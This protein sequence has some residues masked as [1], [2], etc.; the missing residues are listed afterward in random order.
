[1]LPFACVPKNT[2]LKSRV[3]ITRFVLDKLNIV[4]RDSR[5]EKRN[6][7]DVVCNQEIEFKTVHK[8]I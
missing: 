2:G 6:Y 4:S 8:N 1:L 3:G 5:V 7:L